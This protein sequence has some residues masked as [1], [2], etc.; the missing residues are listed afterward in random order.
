MIG[1]HVALRDGTSA[2]FEA[3]GYTVDDVGDLHLVG[4]GHPI[5]HCRADAWVM[6]DPLGTRLAERW[7][8]ENL[9]S[10]VRAVAELLGVRFGHY[11]HE[12][13]DI[14]RFRNWRLNDLDTFCGVIFDAI[15]FEHTNVSQ[16]NAVK[17][18]RNLVAR[19][20]GVTTS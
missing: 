20:F 17:E 7:P 1:F 6:I 3:D 13:R 9:E 2:S 15:G 8:P 5:F 10:A 14:R 12:L 16:P 4:G 11:V 19:E 18:V